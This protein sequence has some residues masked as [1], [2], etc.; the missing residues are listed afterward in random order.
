MFKEV[1]DLE[2]GLKLVRNLEENETKMIDLERGLYKEIENYHSPINTIKNS[3]QY[4]I[5]E[6]GDLS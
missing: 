3:T 4:Q 1:E 6:L 5:N 2:E